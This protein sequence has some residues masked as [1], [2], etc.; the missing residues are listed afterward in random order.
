MNA[1]LQGSVDGLAASLTYLR[2]ATEA[3]DAGVSDFPRLR[4]VLANRRVFDVVSEQAVADARTQLSATVEPQAAALLTRMDA[5]LGRLERREKTL[6]S[7]SGL[8][9]ARIQQMEA[10]LERSERRREYVASE[11]ET[12]ELRE[13][14]TQR[15]RLAYSLSKANLKRRKLRMSMA[16]A[17]PR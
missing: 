16:M 12:R 15:D 10:A 3:L 9:E 14:R 11:E 1:D 2:S 17:G 7:K 5:E 4:T 6:A 13:L 8:Q